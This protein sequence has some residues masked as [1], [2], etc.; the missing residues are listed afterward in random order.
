M[1]IEVH[2]IVH[3]SLTYKIE[4]FEHVANV[5]APRANIEAALE[6]A[7]RYTNNL[8]GSWSM[9][10]VIQ[11][12]RCG[13]DNPDFN[14]NVTVVKPLEGNYGHRSTSVGDRMIVDGITYEV[15]SFGFEVVR[16]LEEMADRHFYELS[17]EM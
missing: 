8:D 2:H 5:D 4:G 13:V 6:Y 12:D 17:M 9:G 1:I 16:D 14:P 15:A 10:E 11:I 7:Y 3:N